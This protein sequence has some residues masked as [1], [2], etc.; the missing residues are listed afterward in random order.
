MSKKQPNFLFLL[1]DQ[2]RPDWL[3]FNEDLP[4]KTPNLDRL[5]RRGMR[6]TDAF[7]PSPLCSPARACLATGRDYERCGVKD[8]GQNTPLS[9]PT[10]YQHL[11]DVGYK[12][13]GV[14]KFDLH[15]PDKNWGL[16]GSKLLDEYGF[17]CGIDNEGTGETDSH[18]P[19]VY[20]G[21]KNWRMVFDGQYKY[22]AGAEESPLLYDLDNDPHE[23]ENIASQAPETVERFNK[24]ISV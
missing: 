16:N 24:L 22:V 10:Y 2:H 13:C 8:N 6:F 12:V 9:L 21:L 19:Y 11:R 3:G 14:G 23:Q 5:C 4:I 15:K 7:T 18:R 17:S 1:P 20:S